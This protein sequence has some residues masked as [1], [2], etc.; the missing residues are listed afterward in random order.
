LFLEFLPCLQFY[1][2]LEIQKS[3]KEPGGLY[4]LEKVNGIY[5]L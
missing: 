5:P 3:T 4:L 1:S 2:Q